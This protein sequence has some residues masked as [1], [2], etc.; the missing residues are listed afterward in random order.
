MNSEDQIHA[1]GRTHVGQRREDNQDQFLIAELRKSMQIHQTSLALDEESTLFGGRNGQLLV[2]ADGMGGHAS[3]RRASNLAVDHLITQLLNNV[4]WFLHLDEERDQ[5]FI[6]SLKSLLERT[7]LKLLNESK[8][9]EEDRGMG[10]TLTVAY[11]V[12]PRMYVVHAGD[13][14]CYLVRSG[15]CSQITTD[16]TLARQLVDAGSMKPEDEATSRWSNVLWNVLGG[17]GENQ[18]TA[19]VVRVDLLPNDTVILCSD[20]LS[21]YV[22]PNTIVSVVDQFGTDLQGMTDHLIQIANSAGGVDNITVVVGQPGANQP[23]RDTVEPS[24]TVPL[25]RLDD[26]SD[27]QSD[28]ASSMSLQDLQRFANED[29]LPD[30]RDRQR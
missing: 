1:A 28:Q 17:H 3:G 14:R 10:T 23:E 22:D 29:T 26:E 8:Q 7:N 15:Q 21:R 6:D 18:F 4:H 27:L 5:S 9:S 11:I 12:W 19:Q 30:E 16:H 20:G 13:S 2:V 24:R 25:V